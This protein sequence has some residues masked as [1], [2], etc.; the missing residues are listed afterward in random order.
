MRR[1]F[2]MLFN[3]HSGLVGK[4][5]FLSPSNYH[6][7]NYDDQKLEARYYAVTSAQR[8]SDI[9]ALAHEAIRLGIKLS[10]ANQA[11]S[12]YVNDAIGYK[13][14][15]EQILFFS[16]NCFG[17]ADTISFR[18]NK[19]RIHDLKTGI[20]ATSEKQLE[21]Y[22]AIF[23]LEYGISPFDIEIELRIYQR[24]EI[25]IF[26]PPPELI[27]SIMERIIDF[28]QHINSIKEARW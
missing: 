25:R 11:L 5:A 4:H 10:K 28:D 19:L 3:Q 15:C 9:H 21:V 27:A 24:D 1:K 20:T 17:T 12:T 23:C 6:W 2:Y 22:A 18:R 7:L 26:E 14:S 16:E 8:G 13:M